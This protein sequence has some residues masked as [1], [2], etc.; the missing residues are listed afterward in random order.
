[1]RAE[2]ISVLQQLTG[3]Q[4]PG[5]FPTFLSGSWRNGA[6]GSVQACLIKVCG[7][8]GGTSCDCKALRESS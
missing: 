2:S 1:M 7:T 6:F 4:F 5:K 8:S 3:N